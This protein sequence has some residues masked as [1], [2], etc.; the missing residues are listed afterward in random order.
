MTKPESFRR[1]FGIRPP[2]SNGTKNNAKEFALLFG[3]HSISGANYKHG[4]VSIHSDIR[5]QPRYM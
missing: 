1:Y 2:S 3:G 5:C 4:M